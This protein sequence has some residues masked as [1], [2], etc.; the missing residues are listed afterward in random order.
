MNQPSWGWVGFL[1]NDGSSPVDSAGALQRRRWSPG[2]LLS[3]LHHSPQASAVRR[4]RAAVNTLMLLVK[5][6]LAM[7]L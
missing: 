6:F 1:E 5:A 2:G 7:Q 3:S 4:S